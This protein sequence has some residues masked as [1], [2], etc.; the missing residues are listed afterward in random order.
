MRTTRLVSFRFWAL[1]SLLKSVF[2]WDGFKRE[3]QSK[4]DQLL[5]RILAFCR[6]QKYIKVSENVRD[7]SFFK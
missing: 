7:E 3:F 4:S 1:M 5:T 2:V 6:L